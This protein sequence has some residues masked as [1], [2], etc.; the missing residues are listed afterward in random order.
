[1]FPAALS[2]ALAEWPVLRTLRAPGGASSEPLRGRVEA[3]CNGVFDPAVPRVNQAAFSLFKGGLWYALDA[4]D[5][6]HSIFQDDP[7]PE[8]SYWHGMLHRREGDFPNAKY[9]LQRAGR[10]PALKGIP[11]FDPVDFASLC[12]RADRE[13]LAGD[14]AEL[15]ALQRLEWE[16]LLM[17]AFEK[18]ARP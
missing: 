15:L 11:D 13:P 10:I 18:A 12:Q 16:H 4:L 7:S 8:G 6:A 5:A 14:P 3:L 9:W 1:M 2:A 17:A